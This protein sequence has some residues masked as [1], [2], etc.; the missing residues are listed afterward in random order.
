MDVKNYQNKKYISNGLAD[1]NV[2]PNFLMNFQT[3]SQ[4]R[5]HA[6]NP[7]TCPQFSTEELNHLENRKNESPLGQCTSLMMESSTNRKNNLNNT[8]IK[9]SNRNPFHNSEDSEEEKTPSLGGFLK[10]LNVSRISDDFDRTTYSTVPKTEIIRSMDFENIS[11][12]DKSQENFFPNNNFFDLCSQEKVKVKNTKNR[13]K[14]L[15][16]LIGQ[17]KKL[18]QSVI[19]PSPKSQVPV[20]NPMTQSVMVR[21][22]HKETYLNPFKDLSVTSEKNFINCETGLLRWNPLTSNLKKN[23]FNENYSINKSSIQK[24]C[25]YESDEDSDKETHTMASKITFSPS[26]NNYKFKRSKL[27]F[28]KKLKKIQDSAQKMIPDMNMCLNRNESF[29]T[30]NSPSLSIPNFLGSP[31]CNTISLYRADNAM[32]LN[33]NVLRSQSQRSLFSQN[34]EKY[35]PNTFLK[36]KKVPATQLFGSLSNTKSKFSKMK[37]NSLNTFKYSET[38][39]ANLI[40]NPTKMESNKFER[41][42]SPSEHSGSKLKF[43][44]AHL[45]D[46]FSAL[47]S[48]FTSGLEPFLSCLSPNSKSIQNNESILSK[49]KIVQLNKKITQGLLKRNGSFDVDEGKELVSMFFDFINDFLD[50]SG[51]FINRG[52]LKKIKQI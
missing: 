42:F 16:L 46:R 11:F 51:R 44:P 20:N 2:E 34:K 38:K 5:T 18:S 32:T 8:Q 26:K 50:D 48:S 28:F 31:K 12:E 37:K 13:R 52:S 4:K 23:S 27:D 14:E 21:N 22:S 33:S 45:E 47:E 1:F 24:N 10:G 29:L 6:W 17:K 41:P 43:W 7:L 19:R 40:Q 39:A 35:Y 49:S 15:Q 30:Q 9:S 25:F 3:H 36:K